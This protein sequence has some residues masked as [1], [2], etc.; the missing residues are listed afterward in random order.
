MHFRTK[1]G[2]KNLTNDQANKL[3]MDPDYARRDLV[4]HIDA[5]NTA[6]WDMFIQVIPEK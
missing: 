1:A 4:K 3:F 2:I 6:E 5:G